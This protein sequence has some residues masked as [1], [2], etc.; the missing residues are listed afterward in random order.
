MN[1]CRVTTLVAVVCFASHAAAQTAK[2]ETDRLKKEVAAL[3]TELDAMKKDI[4]LLKELAL[5]KA[6]AT[7]AT[8]KGGF[9]ARF[10]AAMQL[11]GGTTQQNAF[12]KLVE[13]AAQ[14]GD[15]VV[16]TKS[17]EKIA[18]GS[19]KDALIEKAVL[20]LARANQLEHAVTLA[21][22]L[23]GGSSRDALF[24]KLAKG[25]FWK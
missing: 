24:E 2:D 14:A 6:S 9:A 13:D 1:V 17:L 23:P 20:S 25:E 16:V 11:A 10:D 19:A 5:G 8:G 3:R 4:A 12:S 21:K 22:T 7:T 15:G 18:G